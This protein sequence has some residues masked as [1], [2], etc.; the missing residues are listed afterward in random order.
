MTARLRIWF[1]CEKM[2]SLGPRVEATG[3][4]AQSMSQESA[5]ESSVSKQP[6]TVTTSVAESLEEAAAVEAAVVP[7]TSK[8]PRVEDVTGSWQDNVESVATPSS[9]DVLNLIAS[10]YFKKL[11]PSTPE[12]FNKFIQYMEQVRKVVIVDVKTGSLEVIVQCSSLEVLEK[13]WED[14]STGHLNEMA[15]KLL[16]TERILR[17]FGLA[18]VKLATT[19]KE[20]EYRACRDLLLSKLEGGMCIN[21]F[22]RNVNSEGLWSKNIEYHTTFNVREVNSAG[23]IPINFLSFQPVRSF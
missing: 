6:Q 10:T 3:M 19:I 22:N 18:E 7:G 8:R 12:E 4:E 15:Q 17:A 2:I 11:D 16:V 20:E 5:R 13:L 1:D 21:Q 9:Q 23:Y 14:Y